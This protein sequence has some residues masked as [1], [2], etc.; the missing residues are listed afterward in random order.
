M[1]LTRNYNA[2]MSYYS[3]RGDDGT[4]GLL[5][6]GRLKKNDMRIETLGA[7]DEASAA[8]GQARSS[9]RD[10]RARSLLRDGQRDLYQLMAEV[11]AAP[12]Q[13]SRFHFDPARVHWLEIG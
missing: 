13:A 8:L 1:A 9:A 11:S 4:T 6:K 7:L 12:E 3:R 10:S 2:A 5:G